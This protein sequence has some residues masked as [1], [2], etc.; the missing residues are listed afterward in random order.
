MIDLDN[1]VRQSQAKRNERI[2]L[3]GRLFILSG[4]AVVL[5]GIALLSFIF[6]PSMTYYEYADSVL[7]ES[8]NDMPTE[9]E[10]REAYQETVRSDACTGIGVVSLFLISGAGAVAAPYGIKLLRIK[11]KSKQ[12]REEL[13]EFKK[14][15]EYSIKKQRELQTMDLS[16]AGKMARMISD[17]APRMPEESLQALAETVKAYLDKYKTNK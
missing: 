3:I 16:S 11:N 4:F 13:N 2:G 8:G 17:A 5:G 12:D 1:G 10:M 14:Y 15:S 6:L 9:T 7:M